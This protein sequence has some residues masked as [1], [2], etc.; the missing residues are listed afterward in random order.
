VHEMCTQLRHGES[1]H[2]PGQA[3][4]QWLRTGGHFDHRGHRPPFTEHPTPS[5]RHS[6]AHSIFSI[7]YT[8]L[9]INFS[10]ANIFG[11]K[12]LIT[13]PQNWRD[14]EFHTHFKTKWRTYK[15]R[16]RTENLSDVTFSAPET[17]PR[18]RTP[19]TPPARPVRA[20][21]TY[22]LDM[23]RTF[24]YFQVL[25]IYDLRRKVGELG[26]SRTS[27]LFFFSAPLISRN[28]LQRSQ[29]VGDVAFIKVQH[30]VP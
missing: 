30:S 6:I 1:S 8:N 27:C 3:D 7:N 22:F 11:I 26:L 19:L 9:P 14:F 13:D 2:S 17:S 28:S 10:R 20:I 25:Q 5:S 15:Q 4:R 23:P 12:N 16:M 18:R 29:F 24:N 21:G